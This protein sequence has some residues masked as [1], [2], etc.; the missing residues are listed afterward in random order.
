MFILKITSI[1]LSSTSSFK[2]FK[3]IQFTCLK[4]LLHISVFLNLYIH[5]MLTCIMYASLLWSLL[6]AFNP[7]CVRITCRALKNTMFRSHFRPAESIVRNET[8][9]T[10]TEMLS[11]LSWFMSQTE[12]LNTL[13]VLDK[14]RDGPFINW[15]Y[16]NIK[17]SL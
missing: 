14:K 6:V 11:R 12:E 4:Y 9:S 10:E 3:E 1:L 5:H 7:R 2:I 16:T 8:L 15:T 13:K 17:A